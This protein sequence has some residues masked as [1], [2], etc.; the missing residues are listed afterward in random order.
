M[1]QN[2]CQKM[3][4]VITLVISAYALENRQF[5]SS[6]EIY[7]MFL[8]NIDYISLEEVQQIFKYFYSSSLFIKKRN[9]DGTIKCCFISNYN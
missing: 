7:D 5:V 9:E 2:L 4:Y 1:K 3:L 8:K 6:S